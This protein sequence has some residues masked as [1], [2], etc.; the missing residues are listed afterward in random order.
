[1]VEYGRFVSLA[2]EEG[3]DEEEDGEKDDGP[4]G[5]VPAFAA[6]HEAADEGPGRISLWL[7]GE[8]DGMRRLTLPRGV[9][10]HQW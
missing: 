4:V 2:H 6:D 5:P 8:E 1:M 9:A 10:M 3:K 7:M